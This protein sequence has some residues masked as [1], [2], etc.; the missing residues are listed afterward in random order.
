MLYLVFVTPL[1]LNIKIIHSFIVVNTV[2]II[3]CVF[4]DLLPSEEHV[5][6]VRNLVK[7]LHYFANSTVGDLSAM[8]ELKRFV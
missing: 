4:Q 6:V 7:H 3:M 2:C 5:R 1:D 8:D